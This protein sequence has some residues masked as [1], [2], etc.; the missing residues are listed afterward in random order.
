MTENGEA[1]ITGSRLPRS[2]RGSNCE[3]LNYEPGSAE[4]S[5]AAKAADPPTPA[6]RERMK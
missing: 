6:S 4:R 3:Y 2:G 1:P 5:A